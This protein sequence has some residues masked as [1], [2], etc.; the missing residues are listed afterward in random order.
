MRALPRAK[1]ALFRQQQ[2]FG[3]RSDDKSFMKARFGLWSSGP[4]A[5]FDCGPAADRHG[6][7]AVFTASADTWQRAALLL[8]LLVTI[9]AGRSLGDSSLC[10]SSPSAPACGSSFWWR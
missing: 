6:P 2:A 5:T 10:A 4:I 7:V 3:H 1:E 8:V 9:G